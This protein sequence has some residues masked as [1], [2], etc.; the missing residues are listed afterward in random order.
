MKLTQEQLDQINV[1]VD[2]YNYVIENEHIV[3]SCLI[4]DNDTDDRI[5]TKKEV[6]KDCGVVNG[7]ILVS[8]KY[9]SSESEWADFNEWFDEAITRVEFE[10]DLEIIINRRENRKPLYKVVDMPTATDILNAIKDCK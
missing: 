10:Q 1:T 6:A 3:C 2:S 5:V 9:D 7:K 8:A 4:A